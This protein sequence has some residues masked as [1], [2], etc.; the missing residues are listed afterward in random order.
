[1]SVIFLDRDG[2]INEFPGIGK[3]V[4]QQ[5]E[6]RFIPGSLEA[7]RKLTEAGFEAF[8]ISN[9]GCVSRKLITIEALTEMTSR[10]TAEITKN[11][12]RLSGVFYC[13]H[14]KSDNCE[15]KKPKT[16]LFLD[17]TKGREID[18]KQIYFIGDSREDMEAGHALGCKKLLVLSGR[19]Q[20]A[21]IADLPIK[22]DAVK[23]NLLEAVT[24]ILDKK[25]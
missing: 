14:Q 17:A 19:T 20:E 13:L 7:I 12:G 8:V 11:G 5:S 24:W 1:M 3:Y 9:Q 21:D 25:R 4:V 18:F 6:F 23:K 16:R 2:V 10:M 15:C 22:P